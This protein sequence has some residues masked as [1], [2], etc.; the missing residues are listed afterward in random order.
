MYRSENEQRYTIQSYPQ[1]GVAPSR[2]TLARHAYM[3][4][5]KKWRASRG[6]SVPAAADFGPVLSTV[7]I[8]ATNILTRIGAIWTYGRRALQ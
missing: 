3:E 4:R 5:Q 1:G 7:M 8:R 6:S 2:H